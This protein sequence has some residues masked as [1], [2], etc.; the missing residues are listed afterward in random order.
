M[1]KKL[2]MR[3]I[4]VIILCFIGIIYGSYTTIKFLRLNNIYIGLEKLVSKE[5]YSLTTVA[6]HKDSQTVTKILY[7]DGTGKMIAANGVYSWN[8]SG[9][10]Y[11]V[12]E[13][14]KELNAIT[15]ESF[16]GVVFNDSFA[17]LVPG[18]SYNTIGR[19]VFAGDINNKIKTEKLGG[20]KYYKIETK[21]ANSIKRIW[22][23]STMNYLVKAEMEFPNGDIISYDYTI[24]FD[25]T[26]D[27]Q[28]SLPDI[29][30]YKLKSDT[31]LELEV[32]N[33]LTE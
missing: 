32:K 29:T 12:D 14:A 23:S 31:G 7:K 22:I 11:I 3:I 16:S 17:R 27:T 9:N 26:L 18:Y 30:E 15:D 33:F 10:V 24:A 21:D 1:D 2:L 13:E 4:I 28:V 8:K 19:F 5:N 20:V 6:T 25:E